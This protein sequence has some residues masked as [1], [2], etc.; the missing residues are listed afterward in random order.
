M[1]TLLGR[2]VVWLLSL[3]LPVGLLSLLAGLQPTVVNLILPGLFGLGNAG[4]DLFGDALDLF[5][6]QCPLHRRQQLALLVSGMLAE[7]LL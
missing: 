1:A 2:S 7:G 3:C 5:F 6:A 4:L